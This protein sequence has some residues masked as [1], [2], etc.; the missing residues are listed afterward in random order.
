MTIKASLIVG[1]ILIA[2]WV[3][4]IVKLTDCDFEA[5][6]KC[7]IFHGIG[8]FTG[9]LAIVTVWFDDDKGEER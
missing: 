1:L 4:N 2:A 3:M 7:E 9:P 5:D 8:V 6:Y